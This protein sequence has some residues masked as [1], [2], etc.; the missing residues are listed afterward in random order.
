MTKDSPEHM[1]PPFAASTPSA[2]VSKAEMQPPAKRPQNGMGTGLLELV[3]SCIFGK[4]SFGKTGR[5][6]HDFWEVELEVLHHGRCQSMYHT[7]QKA[8]PWQF[9][10]A[11]FYVILSHQN[12]RFLSEVFLIS[13]TW[14]QQTITPIQV[15]L[16]SGLSSSPSADEEPWQR[17]VGKLALETIAT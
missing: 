16:T 15:S 4:R 12:Y 5:A 13:Y 7:K 3:H 8:T 10:S 17:E 2:K 6:H 11:H 9:K 1:E 14:K